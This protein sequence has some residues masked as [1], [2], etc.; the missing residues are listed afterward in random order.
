MGDLAESSAEVPSSLV[1]GERGRI[2]LEFM[3]LYNSS[4][5]FQN[6]QGQSVK[7]RRRDLDVL[8][9]PLKTAGAVEYLRVIIQT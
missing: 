1:G 6:Y 5:T 7:L 9:I 3:L 4:Q 8:I 2:L